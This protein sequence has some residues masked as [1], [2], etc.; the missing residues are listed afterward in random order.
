MDKTSCVIALTTI[1]AVAL[2]VGYQTANETP[3]PPPPSIVSEDDVS[4][5]SSTTSPPAPSP[6]EIAL[7]RDTFLGYLMYLDEFDVPVSIE[8]RDVEWYLA[9]RIKLLST[10]DGPE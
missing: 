4:F 3:V 2:I 1:V 8:Q 9:N 6:L 10:T 7:S 5:V